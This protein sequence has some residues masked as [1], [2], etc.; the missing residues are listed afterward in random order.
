MK[1][2]KLFV[3]VPLTVV[4]TVLGVSTFIFSGYAQSEETNQTMQNAGQS[5]NQTGAELQ[6]NASD[7]GSEITEGGK[8]IVGKIGEGLENLGK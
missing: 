2:T 6:K 3:I 8:D 1:Y 4:A 7:V 5:A